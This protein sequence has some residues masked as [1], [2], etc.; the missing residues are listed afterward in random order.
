V[1]LSADHDD[2]IWVDPADAANYDVMEPEP[3]VIKA[4]IESL[5]N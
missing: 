4:Y 2:A 1:L 5:E 3:E